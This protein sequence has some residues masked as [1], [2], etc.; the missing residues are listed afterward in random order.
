MDF[1]KE[2]IPWVE[3]VTHGRV[4]HMEEI[5][6]GQS[7]LTWLLDV[8]SE[9]EEKLEL[10]LRVD[11]GKGPLS[12]SELSLSREA[13]VYEALKNTTVRIPRLIGK[14]ESGDALLIERVSGT[15]DMNTMG[16]EKRF[17]DV[18][19]DFIVSLA[20]LHNID[21]NVL[22]LPGF[23]RPKTDRDHARCDLNLWRK[24]QD[25]LVPDSP[26]FMDF[27]FDWLHQNAPDTVDRTVL[28]HGD[29]GP[30]NF[31]FEGNRVTSL[32]DWEFAH[33]GDPLDDL[34]WIVFRSHFTP[35]GFGDL[36]PLFSKWSKLTGLPLDFKRIEY[37]QVLVL[38]RCAVS[39]L[40]A[41]AHAERTGVPLKTIQPIL[42]IY[43]K[44]LIP[45]A[46]L[47]LVS[48]KDRAIVEQFIGEGNASVSESPSWSGNVKP[49]ESWD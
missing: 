29:A 18:I 5:A 19:D 17:K 2:K 14:T 4:E 41:M 13:A 39:C 44:W 32:L 45:R 16:D 31:L 9:E 20:E 25:D 49:F 28:C 26:P 22:A 6:G 46:L 38:V 27:S 33:I 40:V 11:T 8:C 23:D 42:M 7:R 21:T 36:K 10:V 34:A 15:A 37:Y 30:G 35:G 1:I 43:L 24:I 12:G 48:E 3:A 47:P